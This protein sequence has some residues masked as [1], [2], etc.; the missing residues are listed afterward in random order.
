MHKIAVGESYLP[1]G[2][3]VQERVEYNFR[4]GGH[5]LLM[6]LA[7]LTQKEIQAITQGP[8]D[9]GL[10]I[11]GEVMLFLYRFGNTIPWSDA[12]Y[13]W[14]L[15]PSEQRTL[16]PHIAATIGM[17][18]SIILVEATTGI[19]KKIR[20][21]SLP[22]DFTKSLNGAIA[23]QAQH[24]FPSDYDLALESIYQRYSSS[25]LVQVASCRASIN[26]SKFNKGFGK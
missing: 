9:F 11:E 13:S 10:F 14:H 18:L 6:S 24:P 2:G 7:N 1:N 12:P 21:V 25:E 19:V 17:V 20:V 8:A 4:S 26:P 5:E 22:P 23:L 15:V 16:P 3:R